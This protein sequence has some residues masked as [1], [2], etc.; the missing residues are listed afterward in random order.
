M[1]YYEHGQYLTINHGHTALFGVFGLLGIALSYYVLRMIVEPSKWTEGAGRAALWCFNVGMIL[2]VVL[3]FLPE[4][5]MQFA[6]SIKHG[7]WYS[8]SIYFYDK[9][10]LWLWLRVPGDI[11]FSIGV[12]VLFIDITKKL[13]QVKKSAEE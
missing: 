4:G 8:R 1:N 5:F 12:L 3:N 13:L 2:W 7:Y 9:T 6:A 10:D 11:I